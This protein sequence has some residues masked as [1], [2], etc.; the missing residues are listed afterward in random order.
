[1]IGT[2]LQDSRRSENQLS[3]RAARQGDPGESL[4]MYDME[5]GIL[6]HNP[7]TQLTRSKSQLHCHKTA[8]VQHKSLKFEIIRHFDDRWISIVR[9]FYA[10][11]LH[12]FMS[13]QSVA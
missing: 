12:Q 8:A 13:C 6:Q 11:I 2:N 9:R 1:M 5:D 4:M 10:Y 7:T 3:G